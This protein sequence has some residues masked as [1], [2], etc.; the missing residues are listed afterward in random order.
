MDFLPSKNRGVK[1]KIDAVRSG[2]SLRQPTRLPGCLGKPLDWFHHR[3]DGSRQMRKV[4]AADF[5]A[6]LMV[7]RMQAKAGNGLGDN[8]AA[9]KTVVVRAPEKLLLGMRI[10]NQVGAMA[11]ELGAQIAAF[12]AG[13]PQTVLWQSRIPA[14]DHFEFKISHDLIQRH[15]RMI[16]KISISIASNLF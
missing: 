9:G 10:G 13:E 14:A 3:S 6:R 16:K 8:S 11:D 1:D 5:V 15:G 4:D 12:K 7:V 2:P